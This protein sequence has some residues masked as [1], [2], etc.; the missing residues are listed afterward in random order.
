[1]SRNCISATQ[2]AQAAD[3]IIRLANIAKTYA[4][5]LN[6]E[7]PAT[8]QSPAINAAMKQEE[9]LR[10]SGD[11]AIIVAAFQEIAKI[12]TASAEGI[13]PD[14]EIVKME[15]I[16]E[17]TKIVKTGEGSSATESWATYERV[18]GE[19]PKDGTTEIVSPAQPASEP[20]P[21]TSEIPAAP[22]PTIAAPSR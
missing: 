5:K 17:A 22:L 7:Q 1:V 8:D 6:D 14:D 3:E 10:E 19:P 2:A 12:A 15:P 18:P 4:A 20:T 9:Q 11:E 16:G 21:V 13:V